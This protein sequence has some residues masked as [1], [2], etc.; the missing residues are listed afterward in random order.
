VDRTLARRRGRFLRFLGKTCLTAAFILAAYIA[1]VL[2][3]T[4][5]YTAREQDSLRRELSQRLE[6]P[7]PRPGIVL[8]GHAYAILKI[9]SIEV[10]DIVVE[11]TDVASL[12]RGPGHYEETD[13]PWDSEGRVGIAG[14]RTTYGAPFWDLDKVERGDVVTLVTEFGTYAYRVT[15][16]E[17]I[18]PTRIGIL[19]P[20][21]KPTLVLTTCT[22]RFSA[23]ERL[24]VFASLIPGRGD[25][26][27]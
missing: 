7:R 18:P 16:T 27:A 13:D 4:G 2:W 25:A 24:I 12:Q 8:P 20:T 11:G 10:N 19:D 23:A 15:R 14:H 6:D 1:W 22:P 3:G 5:I 21:K 9:P 17:V 26:P